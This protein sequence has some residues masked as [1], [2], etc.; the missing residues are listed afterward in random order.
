MSPV[1]VA[2]NKAHIGA[3]WGAS[4]LICPHIQCQQ[5][6]RQLWPI[7]SLFLLDVRGS[8]AGVVSRSTVVSVLPQLR[9]L[10]ANH[11]S[12][13]VKRSPMNYFTHE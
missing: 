6:A 13:F 3:I 12:A 9:P 5:P 11:I 8:E 7:S 4:A 2:T 1:A 10:A